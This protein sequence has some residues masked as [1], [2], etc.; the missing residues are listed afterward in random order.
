[1]WQDGEYVFC[2]GSRLDADG[3]STPVLARRPAAEHPA[4]SSLDR[5]AHEFGFKDEL[6]VAWAV[7]PLKLAGER[8]RTMLVLD[9]PGGVPLERLLG[10]PMEITSFL[11]LAIGIAKALGKVH[12]RGIV[13]KDIK[14][15]NILVNCTDGKVRLTG[16]GIAS[17]LPRER[18][19]LDPPELIAGTLAYMAPEQTGRMNRS[20]DSRSD[21][22]SLGITFYQM[23]TGSLPF[24][25]SDPMEWV[26]CHI[27]RQPLAPSKRLGNVPAPVSHIIM[28]LLAKTAEERYQTAAG[29]ESDLRRCVAAWEAEHRID[30]FPLGQRDTPDRL[31]IHEKLYGREREVDILLAAFKRIANGDGPKLVLVSGYSGIGKSSVVNELHKVLVPLGGL[32]ALGKFDQYKRDIPYSTLVQAFQGLVRPLLGKSETELAIWS[33]EFL[34]ALEPNARLMTD[35]VPELKLII[36]DQP[37]VP[38]LEPQQAQGRFQLVFRR[39]MG[40]FARPEHPLVLFLDDLQWLD[41]ATLDLIEDLLT[42][43]DLQ[44]LM[45]IGA[46]RDNEVDA[47]HPLMRKVQVIRN[48]GAKI[49]EITLAPLAHDDL[50]QLIADA[51]RC[52][53]VRTASPLA[54]LVQDKTAGNPFF[55]IQFLCSL[56]EEGLLC[57]DHSAA[58]WFWD[59][60]RIHEK[61][62]TDNVVDLMVGKLTR[63]PVA[64]Q[65]ALRQLA[66]LGN[67]AEIAMLSIVLGTPR[68]QAHATLW[69]AVRQE[70]VERLEDSYKFM[71][72]RVQEAAY[73]L[74]PEALRPEVH[75]R[76]GRLLVSQMPREKRDES[77]F[78]IVH[79]LNRG[80]ALITQQEERDQLAELNLIAGKR[81]KGSTAY[82]SALIYLNAGAALLTEDSSARRDELIFALELNRAECEFLTGAL[83]EA[84]QRLAVLSTRAAT[85]VERAAVTC[86][87]VDLYTT[88]G[89]GGH[90]IGVGLE[91]LR[92][93]GVEWSPHPTEEE[94]LRELDRLWSQI[95]DRAIEELVDLPLMSDPE[96]LATL[97]VLIKIAAPAVFTDANLPVLVICRAVNLSLERGNSDASCFAYVWLA[98]VL[99]PRFPDY[100]TGFRFV[101][102]G[103]ELIER[104]GLTRFQARTWLLSGFLMVWTRHVKACR[105]LLRRAFDA[106]NQT[107]DLTHAVYCCNLLNTNLLAAGDSLTESQQQVEHGLAFVHKTRFEF[108]VDI[109]STQLGLI[110]TLRGLTP[111][112]GSFDGQQF[113][114]LCIERR[115]ASNPDLA[116]AE[117]WYWIRKLQGRFFA[118]DHV[119]ALEAS[120]RAQRLLWTSVS[121]FETA[122]YHFYAALSRAAACVS[123]APN[124]RQQHLDAIGTHYRQL[125]VWAESCAENF[126]NRAALVAAELARI[127]GRLLDAERLYEEA[128]HSARANGFINNEA[129]AN[130]LA[131]RFYAARGFEKIARVYLQDARY[132][133]LRWGADGKVL[134]LEEL[135]PH[136]RTEEPAPDPTS[137][138]GTP[139]EHLDLATVIKVS[140]AVSGEI[141]TEK[142]IDTLMRTGIAQAGAER[143]LLILS[144][145]AEPRIAA[146]AA[147]SGDTVLVE[148]R[149]APTA[150]SMLP[151]TLLH[152]VMRTR[153]SVVLDDAA[154][155]PAFAVDP[156]IRQRQTRSIVCLPLINQTKLIGALY[157]ENNLTTRAFAPARVAVLKLL[158]SQAA[159]SL[160]NTRL[161]RDL[162]GR[163]AKIRR[164]VDANIIGILISDVEGRILEANDAFLKIVGYDR[165]DLASGRLRWTELTPPE[166]HDSSARALTELKTTGTIH[167]Y[168]KEYFRKDGSR[169]PVLLGAANLDERESQVVFVLDLTERKHAEEAVRLSE[170]ELRDVIDTIPAMA[171]TTRPDGSNDFANH[172]W[173][174]FTG[175]TSEDASGLGW[176][177]SFHPADISTH[178]EKWRASLATGKPFENE[179][180]IQRASDGEFRWF[181]HRAVPLRDEN[182]SILKWY[183]ISTE[184]DDRKRTEQALREREAKIQGLFDANIIGIF[185]GDI[186]GRIIEANDAFFHML[187]YDREDL[188]SGRVH[189][190]TM[191]PPEWRERNARTRADLETF[192]TV[193]PFEKE[194]FRK[195]GSRVPVL[196]G[197]AVFEPDRVVAFVL[198][199]SER[200][201]AEKALRESEEQWKAVFENNPTMYFMVDTSGIILSV[202]PLGAEQLGFTVD[203]LVGRPVLTLF[204]AEDRK[205]VERNSALCF[206]RPGRTVS[207]EA[208]KI[209]KNAE[210][211]WVREM[212][213]VMLI[214]DRPVALI[215]CEDITERKRVGE[216]LREIQRELAHANRVA[217]MGQLT[218]SIAHEVNQPIAG[219]LAS[220]NAALRWLG[221]ETPDLE[222]A[223][224]SIERVI[225]D[226]RRAGDVIGR[227]RDLVKKTPPRDDSSDINVAIREVIEL[228][229]GEALK[230]RILVRTQLAEGLPL[231]QGDRVQ[232]QQVILNLI[233]NAIE[234]MSDVEGARDLMIKTRGAEPAAVLVTVQDSGP[235]LDPTDPERAF[236]AFYTT[237]PDGMGMGLSICRSIV[238]AHGGQLTATANVP[239]GA[240]FEFRVPAR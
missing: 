230:N 197:A 3:K 15:A 119:S 138:I 64:T 158:A 113:S 129:L 204:H 95:G 25:A 34:E 2:R 108:S 234:A 128:I 240:I 7:R 30:E 162:A 16:F 182:G 213:R 235:G 27:A 61:G 33:R 159:I 26:H 80:I 164:L 14:P 156:Y 216:A 134:Q 187:G 116:F 229:R 176:H 56:A 37:P 47:T 8:G 151:E 188:A 209:R 99:G 57:F 165:D 90:A 51:L 199:I 211:L 194:Y 42:R 36:G 28:K 131:S 179:A 63:L 122:E 126:E 143:G 83:A 1:L 193:Q 21:L 219:L 132:C 60:D 214:K 145:A 81:A 118:G 97:D 142:L 237:K 78:E 101:Q 208:R 140:Q 149:D 227:V 76:I 65:Q 106:A 224:R 44:H 222:A 71:H 168:E 68:E 20:L 31:L 72:D 233:I 141:V 84:E 89:Q 12:E 111:T 238:E 228:T 215:V 185:I 152:Y 66:C 5:L 4:R 109:V 96:S 11:R 153:E 171:W 133:Y 239:R 75:L 202:N 62:Y 154:A 88:L 45:L 73:S 50:G 18:Q 166:W 175:I 186:E 203:E 67:T 200:K 85:T 40:V 163:E 220:G 155:Q 49:E 172:Y 146:E 212:A 207:W 98:T 231:V 92:H 223:R 191:T 226:G 115:F 104:R 87:R 110:R 169:V 77:I 35:L 79:Q 48:T 102:L 236:E 124:E 161:Y 123:A 184:I 137:T 148:L 157:L 38:E 58:C 232:L 82:A 10:T 217:T 160:E 86:L 19:A 201:R 177:A 22:Y 150:A 112:F 139:V 24:A 59:L 206:K 69:P 127:E 70:V 189:R 130:E 46:Y 29:L 105:D 174:E 144:R 183:G 39:F 17:R 167:P 225:R 54:A 198:D 136:L 52:D 221:K 178:V 41:A 23:L 53:S 192:G 210:V 196:V 121:Q 195:D 32:F 93:L 91:Y 190:T 9:D 180:R 103:L 74:I 117:C 125:Q 6:D 181:L 94:V 100:Q 170:K 114:E 43:S 135:Y 147:T 13:H 173:L 55:V 120:S 218:A 107:G 205:A